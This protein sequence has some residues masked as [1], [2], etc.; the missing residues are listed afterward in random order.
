MSSDHGSV[1]LPKNTVRTTN[2]R[3]IKLTRVG[4][5]LTRYEGVGSMHLNGSFPA[6]INNL[7]TIP[8]VVKQPISLARYFTS[9]RPAG[10]FTEGDAT[11]LGML[12]FLE[13]YKHRKNEDLLREKIGELIGTMNVLR[14]A[15]AKYR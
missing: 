6:R 8:F 7:V 4:P 3:T 10:A 2:V 12:L 5:S 15:Q 1:P 11:R 14:S 13:L 9:V